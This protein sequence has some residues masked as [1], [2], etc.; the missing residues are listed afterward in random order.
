M[1]KIDEIFAQTG[2]ISIL[3]TYF[4]TTELIYTLIC[5]YSTLQFPKS[6]PVVAN[7]NVTLNFL[8]V[9]L[10]APVQ[11]PYL[12]AGVRSLVLRS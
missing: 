3:N 8:I 1:M 9:P 2:F 6:V 4:Q 5:D 11:R 10:I 12:V 7:V